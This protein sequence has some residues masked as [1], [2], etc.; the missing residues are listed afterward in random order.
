MSTCYNYNNYYSSD[1]MEKNEMDRACSMYGG[2]RS[3]HRVLVRKPEG[4]RSLGR[5]RHIWKDNIK[6]DLQE[7]GWGEHGLHCSGSA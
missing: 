3:V 2:R 1:Q 5:P 6:V 4:K 7:V